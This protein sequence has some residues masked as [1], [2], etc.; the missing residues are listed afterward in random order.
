M[1]NATYVLCLCIGLLLALGGVLQGCP[2]KP[3]PSENTTPT[4]GGNNPTDGTT[5]DTGGKSNPGP[6][7]GA[8]KI[9]TPANVCEVAGKCYAQ[10]DCDA[11]TGRNLDGTCADGLCVAKPTNEAKIENG[12]IDI[13]CIDSPPELPKGP[14]KATWWGPVETF[15]L[16][17]NTSGVLVEIFDYEGDP[18]LKSPLATMTAETPKEN[19]TCE[20]ACAADRVCFFGKCVKSQNSD[21]LEIGYFSLKDLPTNKQLV[22]R[23]SGP[24]LVSTIQ[25]NLYIPADKV[26]T[27][28]LSDGNDAMVFE[29]RAFAVSKLTRGLIPPTAGIRIPKSDEAVIAGEIQDCK[30]KQIEGARVAISLTPMKLTYFNGEGDNPDPDFEWTNKDGIYAALNVKVSGTGEVIMRALAKVNGEERIVGKFKA[31]LFKDAVTIL[32]TTPW[33]PGIK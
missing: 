2:S 11:L 8:C 16:D 4:D 33:Y 32:T 6:V 5:T 21:G 12:T 28:K 22:I 3:A 27:V 24:N 7:T 9:G 17:S 30:G 18:E 25:Y 31:R 10:R 13:S 19:S 23:T 26:T 14:E 15:G 29:E 20:S 1:R